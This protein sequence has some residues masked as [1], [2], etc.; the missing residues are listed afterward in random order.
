MKKSNPLKEKE[1]FNDHDYYHLF[2]QIDTRAH[3]DYQTYTLHLNGIKK[4]EGEAAEKYL[5]KKQTSKLSNGDYF[6]VQDALSLLTHEYTHFIDFSSS[7]FGLEHLNKLAAAAFSQ[8]SEYLDEQN[9]YPAKQYSDYLR[10][11]RPSR[12][13]DQKH[14]LDIPRSSWGAVES[15]GVIFNSSG[16]P[17]SRPIMFVRFMTPDRV[18]IARAPISVISILEA[19]ATSQEL[20]AGIELINISEDPQ[21]KHKDITDKNL[22]FLYDARLTDYSVCTHLV[23]NNIAC[24]D[25]LMVARIVATL[26]RVVLNTPPTVFDDI[27]RTI[28]RTPYFLMLKGQ[29][30]SSIIKKRMRDAL[31]FRDLGGLFLLL[32]RCMPAAPKSP[33]EFQ[34]FIATTLTRAGYKQDWAKKADVHANQLLQSVANFKLPHIT[35][36]AS[37]GVQNFIELMNSGYQ[38]DYT[39]MHL[40]PCFI[41]KD[42]DIL[43]IFNIE[44]NKLAGV[45]IEKMYELGGNTESWVGKIESACINFK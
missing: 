24:K 19:S 7:L 18:Q 17:S 36:L 43:S 2:T 3:F 22:S 37:C 27:I 39:S 6:R 30:E 45:D 23:A 38:I 44:K 20:L 33:V 1:K 28:D 16:R 10:T 31:R 26:T 8:Q 4:S 14:H 32:A 13:Y 21:I 11:L 9:F 41:E 42:T 40:P 25:I 5:L 15:S 12:Y 29:P 34:T 35:Q